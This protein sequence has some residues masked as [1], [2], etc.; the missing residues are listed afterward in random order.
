MCVLYAPP[1]PGDDS[2][3]LYLA[4]DADNSSTFFGHI[5][6]A[7]AEETLRGVG[8]A[9]AGGMELDEQLERIEQFLTE[10]FPEPETEGG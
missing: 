10:T 4:V 8:G 3:T 6:R 5:G 9:P 2:G 7:K 1:Q